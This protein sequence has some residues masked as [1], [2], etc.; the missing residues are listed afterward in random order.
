[1]VGFFVTCQSE[2]KKS[3]KTMDMGE[4]F[5]L[6]GYEN[7]TISWDLNN[8][9]SIVGYGQPID[10]IPYTDIIGGE[11][12]TTISIQNGALVEFSL[13]KFP[14]L[15]IL[16]LKGNKL[17]VI[18]SM[19][20][21]KN[22][23][24]I[25][26]SENRLGSIPEIS[27]LYTLNNLKELDLSGNFLPMLDPSFDKLDNLK[28]LKLGNNKIIHFPLVLLKMKSLEEVDLSYNSLTKIPEKLE[29]KDNLKYLDVT[30]NDL[31]INEV[32]Q[33]RKMLPNT[34]V[35]F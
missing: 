3:E 6:L 13:A 5:R 33:L 7:P 17:K 2:E 24:H 10:H 12:I 19:E 18:I 9:N 28:V 16:N 21:S 15:E 22:L 14:R 23:N 8:F 25:D 20:N 31:E 30:G 26:L 34:T 4:E 35:I 1:M 11:N 29:K 27:G 32:E